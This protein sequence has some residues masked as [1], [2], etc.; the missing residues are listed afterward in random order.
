MYNKCE[1]EMSAKKKASIYSG[2]PQNVGHYAQRLISCQ[3]IA[4]VFRFEH[5][6]QMLTVAQSK[7]GLKDLCFVLCKKKVHSV[8]C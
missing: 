6:K 1:I 5:K 4:E 2:F 3:M 8:N 7:L